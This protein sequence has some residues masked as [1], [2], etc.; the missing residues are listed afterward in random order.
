MAQQ[1]CRA[2]DFMSFASASLYEYSFS[3]ALLPSSETQNP[4]AQPRVFGFF[5]K[6]LMV[7]PNSTIGYTHF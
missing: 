3:A 7:F 4:N 1:T 5:P 2:C 6:D